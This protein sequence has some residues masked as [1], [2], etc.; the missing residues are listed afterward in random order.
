MTTST[1]NILSYSAALFFVFI[2]TGLSL[3]AAPDIEMV[4]V[5][6]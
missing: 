2:T 4:A 1:G 3:A 6:I 5:A